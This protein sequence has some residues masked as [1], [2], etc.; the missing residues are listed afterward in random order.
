[1]STYS[2]SLLLTSLYSQNGSNRGGG[3]SGRDYPRLPTRYQ[4]F[5]G[6][7]RDDRRASSEKK[8]KRESLTS[9]LFVL[10][11]RSHSR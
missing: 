10:Y 8:K 2:S 3:K 6:A 9:F 11:D 7:S 5:E 1:M 4:S